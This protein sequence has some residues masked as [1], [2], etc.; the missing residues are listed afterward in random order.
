MK[1]IK[2]L[3]IVLTLLLFLVVSGTGVFAQST[4]KG[5]S[6]NGSTGLITS[7]TARIGWENATLGIDV[8]YKFTGASHIP[9]LSLSAFG[10]A[11]LGLAVDIQP[12]G[13]NA[14]GSNNFLITGKYQFYGGGSNPALALA[15]NV[16]ITP[17]L[18][19]EQI[20]LVLNT[21]GTFFT[22]PASTSMAIG[23]TFPNFFNNFPI[24]FS[25][26]FELTVWPSALKDFVHLIV[27]FANYSYSVNPV[28]SMSVGR[29]VFNAGIR[30]GLLNGPKFKLNIDAIGTNLLDANRGFMVGVCF[31]MA[32]M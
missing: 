17:N 23:T 7:P 21:K 12:G 18:I 31:G 16:Q 3:S 26:G 1:K 24:D 32:V 10:K 22:W 27:D 19:A 15:G 11:E 4:V 8:G 30:I 29:G 9:M 28:G 14:G 25:M 13:A 5:M 2:S 20:L 6:T